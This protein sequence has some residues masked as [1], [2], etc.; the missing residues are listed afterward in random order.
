MTTMSYRVESSHPMV[1][2]LIS[3]INQTA[4]LI[5]DRAHAVVVAA[6]SFTLPFGKEI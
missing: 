3:G 4:L 5:A 6:K 2:P 1:G